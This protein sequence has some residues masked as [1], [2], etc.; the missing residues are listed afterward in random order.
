MD[1]SI[2]DLLLNEGMLDI[3]YIFTGMNNK[4]VSNKFA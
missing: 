2:T 4:I 1:L 3:N